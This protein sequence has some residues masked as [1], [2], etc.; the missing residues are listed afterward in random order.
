MGTIILKDAV[1]REPNFLYY[2][3]GSGSVCR[4]PMVHGGRKKKAKK[5][6]VTKVAKVVKAK[7]K[8]KVV[9]KKSK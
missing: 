1:K 6:K 2:V 5:A 8:A 4:S 3:D 7:A 9:A